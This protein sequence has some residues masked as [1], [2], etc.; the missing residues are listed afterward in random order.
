M[1]AARSSRQAVSSL[2]KIRITFSRRLSLEDPVQ[3]LLRGVDQR[4]G[5]PISVQRALA[6]RL[7]LLVEPPGHPGHPAAR[8]P[9]LSSIPQN[10]GHSS[11]RG[12]YE[13]R[14]EDCGETFEI[15]E[16]ISE[17]ETDASPECPKC[18]SRKTE[19]VNRP[20]FIGDP[21]A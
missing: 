16:R 14:C 12:R 11:P 21:L 6:P 3:P 5:V 17:H 19:Q 1:T 7:H 4:E 15:R 2:G 20:G 18:G 13:Y 10:S 8:A 9:H